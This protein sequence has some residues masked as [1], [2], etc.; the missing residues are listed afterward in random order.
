M[1]FI[2]GYP[3][4]PIYLQVAHLI[5]G[6]EESIDGLHRYRIAMF[7]AHEITYGGIAVDHGALHE[8]LGC[9]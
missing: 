6:A 2:S 1:L 8:L 9:N 7:I 5:V 4:K 3:C